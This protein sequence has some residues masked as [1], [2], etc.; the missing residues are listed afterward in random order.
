MEQIQIALADVEKKLNEQLTQWFKEIIKNYNL[1]SLDKCEFCDD[2]PFII[3]ALC[4][5]HYEKLL[6]SLI[7]N[8]KT[9][10]PRR[11]RKSA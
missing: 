4:E 10:K 11:R 8:G 1:D 7:E 5:K 6:K 2:K 9:E 3:L